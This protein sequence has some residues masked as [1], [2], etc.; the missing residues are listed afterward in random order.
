M[1]EYDPD[2]AECMVFTFKE[3][4]L[5]KIA[6]DL[7]LRVTRFSLSVDA[8]RPSVIGSFDPDS[9]RVQNAV[10]GG[11]EDP[12]ALS[13][14]DKEKI[15]ATIRE[16]VLETR[17]HPQIRFSS[18]RASRRPDGGYDIS[19]ALELHGVS[20]D[21]SFSTRLEGAAQVAEVRLHQPDF[22]ITPYRAM[23]GTLRIKPE[24]LVRVRV[25]SR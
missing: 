2:N 21:I 14:S 16:D 3:G 19:G 25:P 9:L 11:V 24:V 18:A 13:A 7:A 17:H 22:G 12:T 20:R 8:E 10:R 23:M 15:A 5:S 6:H 4:L 1:A